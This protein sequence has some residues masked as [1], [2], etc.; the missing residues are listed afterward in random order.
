VMI[1]FCLSAATSSHVTKMLVELL[2]WP[3]TFCGALSGSER[4][5]Q[6]KLTLQ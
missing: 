6:T 4:K 5:V 3:I 1:P 2:F